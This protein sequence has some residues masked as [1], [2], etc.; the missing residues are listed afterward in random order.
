MVERTAGTQDIYTWNGQSNTFEAPPWTSPEYE[1]VLAIQEIR[2][3]LFDLGDAQSAVTLLETLLSSEIIVQ[4]P[5][6][7]ILLV[8]PHRP[9]LRRF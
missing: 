9:C 7:G 1:Q 6:Y 3:I 5:D 8:K 2:H 4:G